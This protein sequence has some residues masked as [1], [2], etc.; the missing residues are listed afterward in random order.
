MPPS[1]LGEPFVRPKPF[2][3]PFVRPR[4]FVSPFV[5][6][7]PLVSPFVRPSSFVNPFV[8]PFV[9]PSPFVRPFVR[10]RRA[11]ARPPWALVGPLRRRAVG[12]R[13]GPSAEALFQR[14]PAARRYAC[15]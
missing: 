15:V 5:R 7:R 11:V 13:G 4:P 1:P 8:R 3:I 6:P 10:A 2:V 12:P 9:R 14:G